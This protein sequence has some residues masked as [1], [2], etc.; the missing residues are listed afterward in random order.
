MLAIPLLALSLVSTI[1]WYKTRFGSKY[2]LDLLALISGGASTMF[3]VDMFIEYLETGIL[4][5][6]SLDSILAAFIL[7]ISALAI[8]ILVLTIHQYKTKI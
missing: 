5:N 2:R 4:I 3:L 7:I 6:T 1:I 8:W